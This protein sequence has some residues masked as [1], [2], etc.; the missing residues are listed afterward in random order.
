MHK[1]N[2]LVD[3]LRHFKAATEVLSGQN[4]KM[5]SNLEITPE[6]KTKMIKDVN[7]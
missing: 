5:K 6:D 7:V 1:M 2:T 3:L 4:K